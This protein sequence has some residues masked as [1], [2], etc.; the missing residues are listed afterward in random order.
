MLP[1]LDRRSPDRPRFSAKDRFV[2]V[3]RVEILAL[4]KHLGAQ[5]GGGLSN[6]PRFRRVPGIQGVARTMPFQ[7]PELPFAKD[8]LAPHMSAETLE[9][10]H[11]KHHKAYV[12][13][14][15][16]L[17]AGR[18]QP[19]RRLA[20]AGRSR[21]PSAPGNDKLFN[22]S[23]Q[24]WNHSFFWQCLAPAQGQQ[25]SGKLAKLIDDALRQRRGPARQAAGGSGQPFRQRLGVAG[26]RP[27]IAADH[28]APRCR[29]ADRP[30]GHGAAVHARC[31]GACLLH[32][33]SQRAAE[34]RRRRCSRTSSTGISSR[35]N[36]DGQRLR[37]RADQEG[38]RARPS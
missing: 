14:T 33:L 25:P 17:I 31:V 23:A 11:G 35:E 28:L 7:L 4:R 22:N 8:A 34:V 16:E 6:R 18:R 21:E 13:K 3:S 29:H 27:R 24:L 36:L 5:A 32:R 10:H 26:A 20:A 15:N 12:N 9:F 30:R 37:S 2:I 38:A 1:P 19:G